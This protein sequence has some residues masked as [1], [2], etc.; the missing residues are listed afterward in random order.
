MDADLRQSSRP[1]GRIDPISQAM[2]R[3]TYRDRIL[4]LKQVDSE[5][6]SLLEVSELQ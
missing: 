3:G 6:D 2:P 1:I 5:R 4:R